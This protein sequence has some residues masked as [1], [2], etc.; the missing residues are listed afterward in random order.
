MV[1]VWKSRC[2]LVT[3]LHLFHVTSP[4]FIVKNLPGFGDLPFTLNIGYIGVGE[5]EEV[6]L[7]YYFVESQ[8]S[9]LNDPLLLWLVGGP[10]CS[11]HSAFFYE[12]GPLMFNY[13]DYNGSFP[14]LLL[15]PNTWTKVLNML[16]VD[17]PVGTGYSYAK[18]QE[19]Y[20][21][22]DKQLVEHSL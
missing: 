11:A 5:R 1:K 21:S 6:Q 18:T 10:G 7:Y 20:Y 9:P 12:N 3:V 13:D 16:Y 2:I 17:V 4:Y 22:N 14:Q 19:G 8:R 15:N